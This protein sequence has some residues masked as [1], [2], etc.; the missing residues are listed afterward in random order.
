MSPKHSSTS[1]ATVLPPLLIFLIHIALA[2]IY[3][4]VAGI[5]IQ[6]GIYPGVIY[7]WDDF[8]QTIPLGLLRHNLLESIGYLHAQPPLYN[9]Y[10]AIFAKICYPYHLDCLHYS[11][12]IV[13]SL[14]ATMLYFILLYLTK[15]K[16]VSFIAAL[17]FSLQ[18]SLF[19]YEAFMLYTLLT[20]FLIT[21]SVLCL[22]L[23]QLRKS[24]LYLYLWILCLSLMILTRGI[25]HPIILL[26]AIPM[27]G[28]LAAG[29]HSGDDNTGVQNA[30]W[31]P[32]QVSSKESGGT[33]PQPGNRRPSISANKSW[34]KV[35]AVSL[36]ISMLSVGWYGK[37]YVQYGFFGSSSWAGLNLWRI[38]GH[39]YSES[40]LKALV[41]RGVLD[42]MVVNLDVFSPLE[43]YADYGFTQ[44]SNID[45]L[46]R[47]NLDNI[48]VIGISNQYLTNALTLIRLDPA[49][50]LIGIKDAYRVYTCHS[51]ARHF[52]LK[53]NASRIPTHITVSET[54]TG[55]WLG[56]EPVF[57]MSICSLFYLLLPATILIYVI[58]FAKRCGLVP[59]KRWL[60]CV[61]A[62]M[63]ML[64]M[65]F[66]ITYTTLVSS[67]FEVGE[68]E[69]FKFLIEPIFWVFLVSL[70][71]QGFIGLRLWLNRN[72]R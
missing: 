25:Y 49:R 58:I 29:K 64:Y 9:L 15:H 41:K 36:L 16:P 67:L 44:T 32:V 66:I 51:S 20:S 69:R 45:L 31:T 63:V 13:G 2:V 61:R 40:E 37:N 12:I 6:A 22:V 65:A 59:G 11:N 26:L 62:D 14:L 60:E 8:W 52:F 21:L 30:F 34:L 24:Y 1:V 18:P 10:G 53:V 71:Y 68:N 39:D 19:L 47:P 43:K 42:E 7:T 72:V 33:L 28:I 4:H 23:F 70:V 38:A 35:L 55:F 5:S 57:T 46:S 17:L 27:V 48:N 3:K 50:Y 54:A 56:E